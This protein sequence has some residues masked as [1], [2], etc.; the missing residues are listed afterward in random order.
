MCAYSRY[1]DIAC[2]IYMGIIMTTHSH[3]Y[4]HAHDIREQKMCWFVGFTCHR[5]RQCY[6]TSEGVVVVVVVGGRA[7]G[8]HLNNLGAISMRQYTTIRIARE[9]TTLRDY[10]FRRCVVVSCSLAW[11]HP[12]PTLY[13]PAPH[14]CA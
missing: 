2:T 7:G 14:T 1:I 4:S 13:A 8:G 9:I 12:R 10:V 6:L 5:H 11:P 3:S